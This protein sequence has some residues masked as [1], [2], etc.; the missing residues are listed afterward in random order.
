MFTASY[1]AHAD[2]TKSYGAALIISDLYT[3]AAR[4]REESSEAS[5][6]TEQLKPI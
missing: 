2:I 1:S 4:Q 6:T 5:F 3:K